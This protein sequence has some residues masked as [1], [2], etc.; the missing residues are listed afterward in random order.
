MKFSR[1]KGTR[2]AEKTLGNKEH[3]ALQFHNIVHTIIT[4]KMISPCLVSTADEQF[5]AILPGGN[6]SIAEKGLD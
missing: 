3:V 6:W 2:K 1:R 5:S 4:E